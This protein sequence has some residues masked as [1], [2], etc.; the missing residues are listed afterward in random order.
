[1]LQS[2]DLKFSKEIKAV[3]IILSG[4]FLFLLG[5]NF[6][7]STSLFKKENTLFALYENV[8]GLQVGTK[9]TVNGLSVGK[10][11][12]IDFLPGTNKILVSFTIRN[13]VVFRKIALLNFTKLD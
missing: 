10:V 5:Y 9:V 8:E 2:K 1:M 6:L 13:D 11:A 7:N 12:D 4:I 3:L